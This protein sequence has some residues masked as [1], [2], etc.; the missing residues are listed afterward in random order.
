MKVYSVRYTNNGTRLR[1][2]VEADSMS[3][4]IKKARR[5]LPSNTN[6][7]MGDAYPIM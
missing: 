5:L 4:A 2:R 7:K 6:I 1:I 3:E